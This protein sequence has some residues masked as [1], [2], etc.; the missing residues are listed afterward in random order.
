MKKKL[1]KLTAYVCTL[2]MLSG[3]TPMTYA[4]TTSEKEET[5]ITGEVIE[6]QEEGGET[7][8]ELSDS[9]QEEKTQ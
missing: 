5:E 7:D 4:Q 8:E 6:G 3:V 1:I 2:T 9:T